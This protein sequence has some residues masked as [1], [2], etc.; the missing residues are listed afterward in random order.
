MA[1]PDPPLLCQAQLST[2]LGFFYIVTSINQLGLSFSIDKHISFELGL[3][4]LEVADNLL[5]SFCLAD[6]GAGATFEMVE[7]VAQ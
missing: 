7:F 4:E 5:L 1:R 6:P 3:Q 2:A